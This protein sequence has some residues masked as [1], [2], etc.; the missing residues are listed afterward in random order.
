MLLPF[1]YENGVQPEALYDKFN[2]NVY[3]G[4]RL[5][6]QQSIDSISVRGH[7]FI[8]APV[9]CG[10]V[11]TRRAHINKLSSDIEYLNSKDAS[12]LGSRN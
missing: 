1:V 7:Q 9:P 11:V 5:T 12:I 6:F 10:V 8:G 2:N 4:P 3:V